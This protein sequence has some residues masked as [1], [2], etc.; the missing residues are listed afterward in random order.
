MIGVYDFCGHYDWTFEWL[1]KQGGEK[2]VRSY[3]DEAIH[4]DS[5]RHAALAIAQKGI[6][7]MADY[8]GHTLAHE[9]AGYHTTATDEVFRIDM[10]DCPSKGF[11]I[12]NG[13]AQYPDYCDH[14]MGWIGP[15]LW[16]RSKA[17]AVRIFLLE[18]FM[19]CSRYMLR[20]SLR[21]LDWIEGKDVS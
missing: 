21:I 11:L 2:L 15:M 8:W 20:R 10:H 5:Q 17:S 7:G 18:A 9:G 19:R 1:R 6:A 16:Q 14:C 13:L 12:R 3:W 4:H